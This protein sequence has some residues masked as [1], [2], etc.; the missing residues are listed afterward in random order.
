MES[1]KVQG[2]AFSFFD[3]GM[4]ISIGSLFYASFIWLGLLLIIGIAILRTGSIKEIIISI[5]GLAT[6]VFI[7][8]G[9]LYVS[10][11]RYGF[12]AVGVSH[13]IFLPKDADFSFPVLTIAVLIISGI[14]V[15]ISVTHFCRQSM[16]KRSSRVRLLYF[17]SGHSL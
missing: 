16:P 13:I 15:L 11:E 17:S 6:P 14:I 2:T 7:F 9:F 8:Y 1:Y 12:N 3:A 4:L 5:L 10:R